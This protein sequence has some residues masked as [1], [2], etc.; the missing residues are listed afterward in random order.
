MLRPLRL[1]SEACAS[2]MGWNH[3]IN[4]ESR[5]SGDLGRSTPKNRLA[6]LS[7]PE[8]MRLSESRLLLMLF[9]IEY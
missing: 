6:V 5:L 9:S 3:R 2:V 7:K 1:R 4:I 8:L